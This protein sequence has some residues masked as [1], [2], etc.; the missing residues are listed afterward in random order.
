MTKRWLCVCIATVLF[1][2]SFCFSSCRGEQKQY[3][4]T[5][6]DSFDTV[7]TVMGYAESEEEFAR[8][9]GEMLAMLA[10]YHR[11]FD[12][13]HS[14]EG[15]ENLCT[16]NERAGKEEVAVNGEI[17][18]LLLYGKEVY[19]LTDGAVN[20]AMGNVLSLWHTCRAEAAENP[21]QAKLPDPEALAEARIHTQIEDLCMDE[22]K[23]TV[24]FSDPLLQLDV[25]AI[26]KGYAVEKIAKAMEEKGVS[27]YVLNAGGNVRVIGEKP[28]GS[29]WIVGIENQKE[30]EDYLARLS[31]TR[32]AL[33]TSGTHQRY[34]TVDG[35]RYHHIIDPDTGMPARGYSSASV[36]SSDS[37]MADAL[38]TALFC[39]S[40]EEGMAL[41]ESLSDAEAIWL[42]EDGTKRMS[43]DFE[44]YCQP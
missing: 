38:S 26:A 23:G 30:G 35:V 32:E 15:M 19:A 20:I 22:E 18:E 12:I 33:V 1:A 34:Y 37:A 10:E 44:K 28:S 41:V 13:Y 2:F 21:E 11:M 43:S 4:V 31:L 9:S 39:M 5:S 24:S 17:I 27:G 40:S 25:G 3:S 36:V 42:L 29:P 7:T 14:Y 6:F 16:V 8:V